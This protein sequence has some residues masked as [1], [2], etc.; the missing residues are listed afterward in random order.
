MIAHV[1]W[2]TILVWIATMV[3]MMAT[4]V[5]ALGALPDAP[6]AELP[7]GVIALVGWSN[8]LFLISAWAWVCTAAWHSLGLHAADQASL[9]PTPMVM[10]APLTD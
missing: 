7:N 9:R 3:L 5:Q 6:P 2:I 4:F 1:T 8:R 10:S